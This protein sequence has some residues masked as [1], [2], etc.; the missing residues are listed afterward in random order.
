MGILLRRPYP[1]C[2]H[3]WSTL[4]FRYLKF[5]ADDS[6]DPP[7]NFIPIMLHG[8]R[9]EYL[10]IHSTINLSHFLPWEHIFARIRRFPAGVQKKLLRR[11]AAGIVFQHF[12]QGRFHVPIRFPRRVRGMFFQVFFFS[13]PKTT[14]KKQHGFFRIRGRTK[15]HPVD[16]PPKKRHTHSWK[17]NGWNLQYKSPISKGKMI[18]Q[19]KLHDLGFILILQGV[20]PE[21]RCFFK[22]FFSF[23][24]NRKSRTSDSV[25]RRMSISDTCFFL[26]AVERSCPKNVR[27]L[28]CWLSFGGCRFCRQVANFFS[29]QGVSLGG[30]AFFVFLAGRVKILRVKDMFFDRKVWQQPKRYGKRNSVSWWTLFS[31]TL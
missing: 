2:L 7:R 28:G 31:L 27:C 20:S 6:S 23:F 10:P 14:K 16:I 30:S 1:Y 13:G 11:Q 24:G 12:V 15:K 29:H 21:V 19:P 17:I 8:F 18:F 25:V 4:Y 26:Q 5:V 3:R 9:E 22:L